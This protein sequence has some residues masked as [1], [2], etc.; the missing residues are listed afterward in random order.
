LELVEPGAR[1]V[2][3]P[4]EKDHAAHVVSKDRRSAAGIDR[5]ERRR[6]VEGNV[7]IACANSSSERSSATSAGSPHSKKRNGLRASA[8]TAP[9]LT[10]F[11][12]E[13]E[14]VAGRHRRAHR[15]RA[16]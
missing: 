3:R 2:A 8:C 14:Q 5:L 16:G 10:P 1:D 4:A 12:N 7:R 9:T 6:R 11:A 13:R 15:L